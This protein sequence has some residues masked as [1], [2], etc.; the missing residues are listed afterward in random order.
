M[1]LSLLQLWRCTWSQ[2]LWLILQREVPPVWQ[3]C[4]SSC[5]IF[6]FKADFHIVRLL[7]NILKG[8]RLNKA[9]QCS[10]GTHLARAWSYKQC[11]SWAIVCNFLCYRLW[12]CLCSV[13]WINTLFT[14]HTNTQ[15]K[16]Q[17][18]TSSCL[19]TSYS[20]HRPAGPLKP[21]LPPFLSSPKSEVLRREQQKRTQ[22]FKME[23]L[24]GP[25]ITDQQNFSLESKQEPEY[26][27]TTNIFFFLP[28]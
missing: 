18:S 24:P 21:P 27:S 1:L 23:G 17:S 5:F 11:F 9:L 15:D 4:F 3:G 14:E 16:E 25:L 7:W 8:N 12:I 13:L 26:V 20:T 2:S 28:S 22:S 10:T 19:Q 6:R